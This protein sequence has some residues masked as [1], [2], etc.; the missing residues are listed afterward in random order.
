MKGEVV[1]VNGVISKR[2]IGYIG[3]EHEDLTFTFH[4]IDKKNGD[5]EFI[6][7]PMVRFAARA[8]GFYQNSGRPRASAQSTSS[9]NKI[10]A[11]VD[12]LTSLSGDF[13]CCAS[14]EA[15]T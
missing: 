14:W 15:E 6:C 9:M 8:T 3:V 7:S 2:Q 10:S 11:L 4:R 5:Q 13:V 1:T 12:H